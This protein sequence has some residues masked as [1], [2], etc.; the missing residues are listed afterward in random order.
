M[1]GNPKSNLVQTN[2]DKYL[3]TTLKKMLLNYVKVASKA[4]DWNERHVFLRNL[5]LKIEGDIKF[6]DFM[7]CSLKIIIFEDVLEQ[8]GSKVPLKCVLIL[9]RSRSY[10]RCS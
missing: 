3:V 2:L 7:E 9:R 6:Y 10:L 4:Y 5:S 8:K 1:T